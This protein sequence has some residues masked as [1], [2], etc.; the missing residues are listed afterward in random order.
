MTSRKDLKPWEERVSTGEVVGRDPRGMTADELRGIGHVPMSPIEA[1]R[2]R[3]LDCCGGSV[4][5]VRYC[6]AR[7]CPSWPFRM[8][9]SPWREKRAMSDEGR[10]RLAEQLKGAREKRRVPVAD[11]DDDGGGAT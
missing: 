3:C 2:A 11:K 9:T 5:E 1:L 8:K 6:T 10:A 7:K 4:A